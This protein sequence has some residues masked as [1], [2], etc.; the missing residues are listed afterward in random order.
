LIFV[1]GSS[2]FLLPPPK[3]FWSGPQAL[4]SFPVK[5]AV[6]ILGEA[7]G[8]RVRQRKDGTVYTSVLYVHQ[9]RQISS[10]FNDHDDACVLLGCSAFPYD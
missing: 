10:S 5:L 8:L 3:R 7:S 1:Q 9:G 4:A 2:F 6:K